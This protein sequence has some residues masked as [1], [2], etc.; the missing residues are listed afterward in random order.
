MKLKKHKH[1]KKDV[2]TKFFYIWNYL[3]WGGAQTYFFGLMKEARKYGEVL[4][5]MPMGSHSQL[6][7]FLDNL[8]IPYQFFDAHTD[9][10]PALNLK[11][12]FQRHWNKL[13]CEYIL[14][15][16]LT[17]FDFK[18]SIV[19]IELAPWQS[20]TFLGWLCTKTKVFTTVHNSILPIPT[21]RYLLWRAKFRILSSFKD[22]HIFTANQDAKDSLRKLVSDEYFERITVVPA[23]I[24]PVEVEETLTTPINRAEIRE[25]YLLPSDKFLVFCV[26]QFIDRK[27]RWLFLE[28]AQK[29]LIDNDDMAFVWISNSKPSHADLEKV[30]TY[31][32][33]EKFI[34]ITSDQVG[35]EHIELFK[36][37]RIADIFALPSYLEGLPISL[38]E[39]MA[40]GIPC[41]STNINGIPEAVKHL[42]T[43]YLIEA[44]NAKKLVEAI[45]TLKYDKALREKL[46]KNGR[47]IVLAN[48]NEKIVAKIALEKYFEAFIVKE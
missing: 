46:A 16:Y 33:G 47:E 10:K 21:F 17:K 44:G 4:V 31:N 13:K 40:L 11:R 2:P 32:L 7:N 6:L 48:F 14:Y 23:Y 26:G 5:I 27:G 42:E 15:R 25:K 18:N 8:E 41:I 24:N 28:A 19:H 9:L 30:K 29:L 43:G 1:S 12:K 20:M 35:D 34:F 45:K 37:L 39:A 3:E 38:L 36:L 22:F